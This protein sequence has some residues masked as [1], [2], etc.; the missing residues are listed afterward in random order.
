MFNTNYQLKEVSCSRAVAAT[1]KWIKD[2]LTGIIAQSPVSNYSDY[3]RLT[4]GELSESESRNVETIGKFLSLSLKHR[5]VRTVQRG[6]ERQYILSTY[7]C[8][9]LK[10]CR[11]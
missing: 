6:E 3:E 7:S 5:N 2:F 4:E 11:Y 1:D 10:S 8:V 9:Y